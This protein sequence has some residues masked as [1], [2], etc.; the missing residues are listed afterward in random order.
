ME[1][2]NCNNSLPLS[3]LFLEYF[4]CLD[5]DSVFIKN[6]NGIANN[7][8]YE[9]LVGILGKETGLP[10][11]IEHNFKFLVLLPLESSEKIEALKQYYG[12][13][14]E[15]QLVVRGVE[16]R[17][18]DTPNLIKQFQNELLATLFDCKDSEE[19]NKQ[20]I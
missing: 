18:Y 5:T 2:T 11:S 1:Q 17:R 6:S 10:I 3:G 14:H 15:G 4:V 12:V 9:K 20:R 13:T 19:G 8:H 16:I 7:D